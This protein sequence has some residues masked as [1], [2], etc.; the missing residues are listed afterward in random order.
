MK[1]KIILIFF[2]L[3]SAEYRMLYSPSDPLGE[4]EEE[5]MD[6]A[7]NLGGVSTLYNDLEDLEPVTKTG[8][9]SGSGAE[10]RARSSGS[11]RTEQL[12]EV[13]QQAVW[14]LVHL[15]RIKWRATKAT[16]AATSGDR[17]A[18]VPALK[19]RTVPI[20]A[21]ERCYRRQLE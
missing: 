2:C 10:A 1:I 14:I 16:V 13:T 12:L 19:T 18:P 9:G 15:E 11:Q 21:P 3:G 4:G 8:S 6:W 17:T 5:E 7:V 20:G